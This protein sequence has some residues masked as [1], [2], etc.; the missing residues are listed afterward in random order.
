MAHGSQAEVLRWS[1]GQPVCVV[2]ALDPGLSFWQGK[3]P[4]ASVYPLPVVGTLLCLR[5]VV[6][7]EMHPA[8]VPGVRAYPLVEV[9]SSPLK[10]R[11]LMSTALY[12]QARQ[13]CW[14]HSVLSV[15]TQ[16]HEL[17]ERISDGGSYRCSYFSIS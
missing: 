15:E 1:W 2:Q 16:T 7:V 6:D 5:A 14:G 11:G 3:S 10:A 4:S 12:L 13:N 17:P 9:F 8:A